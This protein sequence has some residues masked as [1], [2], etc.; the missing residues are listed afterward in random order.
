MC[1]IPHLYRRFHL[2]RWVDDV[3]LVIGLL[4]VGQGDILKRILPF[5]IYGLGAHMCS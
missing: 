1:D 5:F 3:H 2:H 4:L